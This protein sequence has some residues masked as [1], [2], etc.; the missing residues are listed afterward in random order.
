MLLNKHIKS[1]YH[2]IYPLFLFAFLVVGVFIAVLQTQTNQI[3]NSFAST[4]K[5]SITSSQLTI[6]TQEEQLLEDIN[7][8]R[9]QQKEKSVAMSSV[10]K[11]AAAW[12]SLDMVAHNK[13]SHIDSLGRTSDIR[14]TD[15]GY[16]IDHGFGEN[17]AEGSSNPTIIFDALKSN[18]SDNQILINKIYTAV[19]IDME[20]NT[21]GSSY[22]WTL[23]FGVTATSLLPT[24]T[25][26]KATPTIIK[27]KPTIAKTTPPVVKA[28]PTVTSAKPTITK[29]IAS[30]TGKNQ[31]TPSL[32]QLTPT[33]EPVSPDMLISVSVKINGIGQGGNSNPKHR[34]RQVTVSVYGVGATPVT[35]GT[36]YLSYDG[37]NYFNGIIHLGKL[38]EGS[39]FIK[40]V[41][42]NT[43]QVLAQP[44]FQTLLIGKTNVIPPV[45]L[46]QG[47][48][49]G[50]NILDINDYNIALPCFQNS[51]CSDMRMD[52][53]DDGVINVLDYNL[54]LQS[55]EVL[56]GD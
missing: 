42:Q 14:L 1:H 22:Y 37:N 51:R 17:I 40:I 12:L 27:A 7:S 31:S 21:T 52:F 43:L 19:G 29:T 34:T 20:K 10:L 35:T 48:L 28:T 13:L 47:D 25:S 46:Y 26:I 55:Y 44:A 4:T 2:I 39:Y 3:E 50:D 15:C 11:Q 5:C 30:P 38:S 54:F 16:N 32:S 9:L 6:K 23:D 41:S 18:K 36:G 45:N 49:N 8:Y 53:N 56:H 33:A 24:P